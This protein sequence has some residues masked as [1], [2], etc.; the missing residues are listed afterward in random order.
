MNK[1]FYIYISLIILLYFFFKNKEHFKTNASNILCKYKIIDNQ[2]LIINNL[3]L[4]NYRSAI[5]HNFLIKNN[6]ELVINLSKTLDF[7]DNDKIFKFR[8]PIH[9]NLSN[10]SNIGMIKYFDEAYELIDSY[11]KNNKGVLVHCKAGAQRSATLIALYLMKKNNI[12]SFLAKE[13]IQ[14]K[15]CVAFF[16]MTNFQPVLDYFDNKN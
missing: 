6:I 3:W 10:E 13:Y 5:D 4:G 9:D 12:K 15:R 8:I 16:P 11:L 1:N 7:L 2:N 14:N